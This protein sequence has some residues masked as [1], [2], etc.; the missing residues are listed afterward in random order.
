MRT[1]HVLVTGAHR[2]GTTW[3]GRTI[4]HHPSVVYVQEPFNVSDPNRAF[5]SRME[6]SVYYVPGSTHEAAVH[7][8]FTRVLR[9]ASQPHRFALSKCQGVRRDLTLP[10][11]FGTYLL[12][13]VCRSTRV[14]IKDPFALMSAG[15]LHTVFDLHVI[16]LVRPPSP[17]PA[18]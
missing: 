2:S 8:A 9:S 1:R 15:W 17:S 7:A 12:H 18:A 6:A 16:C 14:L 13:G 3:V 10:L 5:G 4:A 11:R